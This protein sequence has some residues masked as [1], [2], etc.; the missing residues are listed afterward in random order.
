[1]PKVPLS[2]ALAYAYGRHHG[3]KAYPM[4]TQIFIDTYYLERA[5][6]VVPMGRNNHLFC[7]S[8]LGAKKLDALH[9]LTVTCKLHIINAYHYLL[10]DLQRVSQH[11]A[12]DFIDFTPRRW[13]V[14]FAD[15]RLRFDIE[16][17]QTS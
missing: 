17:T 10:D 16:R 2:K 11:L 15:K 6:R 4:R 13:K 7:W 9:T 3:L 8:E 12:K 1:M 5:L 14:L